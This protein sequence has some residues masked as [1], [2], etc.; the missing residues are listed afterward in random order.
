MSILR[1]KGQGKARRPLVWLLAAG[2]AGALLLTASGMVLAENPVVKEIVADGNRRVPADVILGEVKETKVGQPLSEEA[3]KKDVEAIGEL[4]YFSNVSIRVF[5]VTGGVKVVFEVTENPIVK[6]IE[7]SG[8]TAVSAEDFKKALPVATGEILN[9]K[10]LGENLQKA[11]TKTF[12]D[13][14]ILTRV[15]DA[16]VDKNGVVKVKLSEI[17]LGQIKIE[18]NKKTKEFVIRR[19]L[20]MKP[21]DVLN[22]KNLQKDLRRV[23]NLGFFDEVNRRFTDTGNP[24]VMDMTIEVKERSTGSANVGVGYSGG[25]GFLGFLEVADDNAFGLG[26]RVNVGWQFGK[27]RTKYDLGYFDPHI[28]DKGT[29]F[30]IDL[31][32]RLAYQDLTLDDGTLQRVNVH[33]DGGDITV[34]QPFG[35]YTK[36]YIRYKAENVLKEGLSGQPLPPSEVP[37]YKTRSLTLSAVNDTRDFFLKPTSGGRH[38]VSV[39]VAGKRLGGDRDFT[40]YQTD[41]SRFFKVGRNNQVVAL[42]FNGGVLTGDADPSDYFRVGGSDTVR[43]YNYL[44]PD[45]KT[46]RIYEDGNR[47]F[48]FNT[49]YR[50]DVAKGLQAVLFVD[51]G[52]AWNE[53]ESFRW[54][55]VKVGKGVGIRIETPVGVMRIDYGLGSAGGG[56]QTYFSIGQAF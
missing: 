31:Y 8:L 19:E 17:R 35:E 56:G 45:G 38:E 1:Q 27:D 28:N 33:R 14:G 40:K 43:G 52:R 47:A 23:L 21:G 5:E 12:Q 24:D 51:A 16:D 48:S 53:N 29:S 25:E 26:K 20:R 15:V 3:V 55:D 42:H 36:A 11:M 46:T 18:G 6:G 9:M 32:R 44:G 7:I 4:G 54:S 2:L 30:G 39:E 37:F 41:L 13:Y 10:K 49:E 50:F 34:G 22:M